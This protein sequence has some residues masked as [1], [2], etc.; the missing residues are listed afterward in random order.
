MNL[1]IFAPETMDVNYEKE[2]GHYEYEEDYDSERNAP[3]VVSKIKE[4]AL[5]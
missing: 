4:A 5:G 1:T 3:A 2:A